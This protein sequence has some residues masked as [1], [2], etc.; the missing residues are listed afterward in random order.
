MIMLEKDPR[1]RIADYKRIAMPNWNYLSNLFQTLTLSMVGVLLSRLDESLPPLSE[2]GVTINQLVPM[3]LG[4]D[5]VFDPIFKALNK[6][7]HIDPFIS[8]T[9]PN[10]T[11]APRVIDKECV[12][13]VMSESYFNWQVFTNYW[14]ERTVKDIVECFGTTE[15]EKHNVVEILKL[16]STKFFSEGCNNGNPVEVDTMLNKIDYEIYEHFNHEIIQE[17]TEAEIEKLENQGD[18]RPLQARIAE[19]EKEVEDLKGGTVTD[20]SNQDQQLTDAQKTIEEQKETIK[21][22]QEDIARYQMR[23]L[24]PAKRKGIALGLTPIQA[25]IFGN[26]L[27]DK[28]GITF[29]NKKEELSL[30]LNCL[31]GQ[32]MSSLANK[33]S[34]IHTATE[35]RLY[36][37]SIFGPFSPSTAK[38]IS[39]DWTEDT[40][41][42]WEED[43]EN[44][45]KDYNES[46]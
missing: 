42:P 27:A 1:W 39:S 5:G 25:D 24:P 46:D 41:A 28:L 40:A 10:S 17:I 31:F 21:E 38:A 35:D 43:G 4:N 9:I 23:G 3:M 18:V 7:L 15:E 37:A 29:V 6:Q 30:I 11:F 33:M 44:N 2:K 32:G 13:D 14:E 16:S 20:H 8:Q 22:L 36:V 34:R 26:Y 12:S 19:L 45:D